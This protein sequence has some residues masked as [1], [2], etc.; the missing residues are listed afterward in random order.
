MFI[1][2][3]EVLYLLLVT[4]Q[5]A[6]QSVGWPVRTVVTQSCSQTVSQSVSQ[7]SQSVSSSVRHDQTTSQMVGG[8]SIRNCPLNKGPL[9]RQSH[10]L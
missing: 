3:N 2:I 1:A 4:S 9:I 8:R 10:P 6:S 7:S 5:S